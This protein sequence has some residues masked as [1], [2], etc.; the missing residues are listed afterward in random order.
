MTNGT[1]EKIG[2]LA[3]KNYINNGLQTFESKIV[4]WLLQHQE[5]QP[6]YYKVR[7]NYPLSR[8]IQT[9]KIKRKIKQKDENFDKIFIP[10]QNR[11]RFNPNTI[12]AEIIPYIHD[13]IPY[14]AYYRQERKRM[15]RP[16]FDAAKNKLNAEYLPNLAKVDKAF[17]ASEVTETD[18]KTR[19]SFSG[20]SEVVYQGVDEMPEK[21][22]DTRD[23]DVLYVGEL[24]ERKNPETVRKSMQLLVDKG[25]KVASVNFQEI[26]L[27]GKTFVDVSNDKLAELYSRTRFILHLSR[28]EGFGRTPV[29]AQRYGCIPVALDIPINNEIL[30]EKDKAWKSC[31]TVQEAV[32]T[33][34]KGVDDSARSYAKENSERFKWENTRRKIKQRLLK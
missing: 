31:A 4:P 9:I 13:I 10:A 32:D 33:V 15:L 7:N 25:F 29:E 16:I 22:P 28:M 21:T 27:P 3:Q 24:F 26:D 19:T 11:L 23:I 8:T 6:I 12:N 34:E 20:T 1:M 30:G 5:F 2:V 17:S 14:T 18:L